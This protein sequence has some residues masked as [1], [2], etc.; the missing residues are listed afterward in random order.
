MAHA[1]G[2]QE[3]ISPGQVCNCTGPQCLPAPD[4]LHAWGGRR[5]P[6]V[7]ASPAPA[8]PPE[9]LG[10]GSQP[11]H[12]LHHQGGQKSPPKVS[13]QAGRRDPGRVE[14][15]DGSSEPEQSMPGP[16]LCL[17]HLHLLEATGQ[18]L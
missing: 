15:E 11:D 10:R 2:G 14:D 13:S 7:A 12:S 5:V 8:H 4:D 17:S 9:G 16:G 1:C 3:G 6:P 18:R